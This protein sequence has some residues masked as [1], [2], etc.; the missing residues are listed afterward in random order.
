MSDKKTP[1]VPE[2]GMG[3]TFGAGSDRYPGTISRVSDSGKT[4]WYKR[5]DFRRTDSNGYGGQ[6][7]YD[8]T[9]NP[10]NGEYR[11]SLT[12]RGWKEIGGGLI[13]VGFRRAYQDP[14]F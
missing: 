1:I 2:V 7:E 5:D 11:V 14:H 3:V 10:D 12:K 9:P 13:G 6:Q 4:F 8:I